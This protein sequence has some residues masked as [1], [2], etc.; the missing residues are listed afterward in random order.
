M[1]AHSSFYT[2]RGR[3]GALFGVS[4]END[5]RAYYFGFNGDRSYNDKNTTLSAA[6]IPQDTALVRA[7]SVFHNIFIGRLHHHDPS[8]HLRMFRAAVLCAKQMVFTRFGS[9]EPHGRIPARNRCQTAGQSRF[10]DWL[11]PV[12]WLGS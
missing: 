8:Y 4:D 1:A 11:R 3:I 6:L 2:D 5:Y 12:V 9:L 7:L 10:T